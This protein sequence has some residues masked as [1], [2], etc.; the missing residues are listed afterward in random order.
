MFVSYADRPPS[1]VHLVLIL[2]SSYST[3]LSLFSL[4]GLVEKEEGR[5]GK[6]RKGKKKN[7]DEQQQQA[8]IV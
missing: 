4:V 3:D 8:I 7:N 1:L 6:K 5:E 2:H